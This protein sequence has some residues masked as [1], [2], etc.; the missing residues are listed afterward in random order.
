M[1]ISTEA[2]VTVSGF[3]RIP[4]LSGAFGIKLP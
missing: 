1:I 4:C 2:R 3:D